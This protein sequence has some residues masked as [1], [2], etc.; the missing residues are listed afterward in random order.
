GISS[1]STI[2]LAEAGALTGG[3][4]LFQLY[5]HKDEGLNHAMLEAARGKLGKNGGRWLLKA[6]FSSPAWAASVRPYGPFD[7]VVSGFAIHH[8]C[9]DRKKELYS[10]IRSLL[11]PGGVFLN[12]EH[13]KSRTPEVE[14]LFEEFYT[15]HLHE[16]FLSV[17]PG[18]SREAAADIY[19]NRPDKEE[20]KPALVE[21]QCG[22]LRETGFRD[23]DC[24]FKV[25]AIAIFGGRK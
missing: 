7:A 10:E 6:D 8:L 15:D 19:R 5:I 13:V 23:V 14:R 21:D 17:D 9:D 4:K 2:S 3:P 18:A 22:W 12:L 1:L 24:F 20:D 25:F 16:F 11:S